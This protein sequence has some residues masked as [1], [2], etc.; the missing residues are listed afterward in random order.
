MRVD[1]ERLVDLIGG[2]EV[3]NRIGW[4][5]RGLIGFVADQI[6]TADEQ[7]VAS[8]LER[9]GDRIIDAGLDPVSRDGR[10]PMAGK[11]LDVAMEVG[12]GPVGTDL[13]RVREST[14][15]Q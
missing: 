15:A 8:N 6:L 12:E 9:V 3:E 13:Q 1:L 2:V 11:D 14:V 7:C 10:N 5:P 4:Q